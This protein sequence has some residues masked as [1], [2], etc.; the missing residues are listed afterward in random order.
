[1]LGSLVGDGLILAG[2]RDWSARLPYGPFIAAAATL[3][4]WGGKEWFFRL[5]AR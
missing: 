5:F 2:K 1:V 3:W 4:V